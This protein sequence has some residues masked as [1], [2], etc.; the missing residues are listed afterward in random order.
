[1]KDSTRYASLNTL[2]TLIMTACALVTLARHQP[3]S[4]PAHPPES[5]PASTRAS[6]KPVDH[7]NDEIDRGRCHA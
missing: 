7:E 4:D 1:M 2:C 3:P 6:D 5:G